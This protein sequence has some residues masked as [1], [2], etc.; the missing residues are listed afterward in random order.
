MKLLDRTSAILGGVLL[1][2]A[3]AVASILVTSVPLGYVVAV[4]VVLAVA[5]VAT[6]VIARMSRELQRLKSGGRDA[7][8]ALGAIYDDSE[9]AKKDLYGAIETAQ[10]EIFVVGIS[11]RS[12]L[13]DDNFF[14]ALDVFLSKRNARLVMLFADPASSGLAQRARDE[15]DEPQT[16]AAD[17]RANRM[18]LFVWASRRGYTSSVEIRYYDGYPAW[19][20]EKI[21]DRELFVSSYPQGSTGQHSV[22]LRCERT[23]LQGSLYDA[24]ASV[25]TQC[26]RTSRVVEGEVEP[27]Q[28]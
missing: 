9:A 5:Y 17:I 20:L 22:V 1:L 15:G 25:G 12:L 6:V 24:F 13:G 18:R 21:D 27:L 23:E 3:G 19:R 28:A 2:I 16:F 10:E 4:A 7:R 8:L 11:H 26:S 14:N